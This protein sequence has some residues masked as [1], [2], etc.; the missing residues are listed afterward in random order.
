MSV[1]DS[2]TDAQADDHATDEPHLVVE[3]VGHVRVVRLNRPHRRNALSAGLM[4][5][6]SDTMA[7]RATDR[8]VWA[9]VLTGTGPDA[10]CSGMDLKDANERNK[11]SA[12]EAARTG[13]LRGRHSR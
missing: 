2:S 1:P 3:D 6:L 8:E 10:F 11:Q 13:A 4:A 12:T 9:V 5:D 7:R